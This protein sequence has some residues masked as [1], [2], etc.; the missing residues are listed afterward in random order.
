M[1]E[2]QG[3]RSSIT[4]LKSGYYMLKVILAIVMVLLRRP[5][6]LDQPPGT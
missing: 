6:K 1:R 3:G 4:P 5:V 2:R